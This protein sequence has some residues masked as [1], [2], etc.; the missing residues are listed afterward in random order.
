MTDAPISLWL[1][2][3]KGGSDSAA[4]QLWES[5]F[6]RLCELARRRLGALPRRLK[7]EE[8]VALSALAA[9]FDGARQGRFA[10][11][12][13]REDLWKLLAT[14]TARKAS[15]VRRAAGRRPEFGESMV[16]PEA[17]PMPLDGFAAP[18]ADAEFVEALDGTS[19]E[20]LSLLDDKLREVAL[21]RLSGYRNDE[22]AQMRNR[23]VKSIE[24]YMAM[25]RKRWASEVS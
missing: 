12:D 20:L 25:I 19:Q 18:V 23:S 3:L 17:S 6:E 24:R 1:Q 8:D 13:D 10:K 14:I 21:L 5:C 2:Q 9:L 11:L 15:N 4:R 7:D 16:G 22:I